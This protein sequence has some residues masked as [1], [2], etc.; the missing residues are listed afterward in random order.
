MTNQSEIVIAGGQESMTNAHHTIN[1]RNGLKMGDGKLKDSMIID[2]LW[3]AM[4][5][6]HM[7]TTAENISEKYNISKQDQDEFATLSQN[8]AEEA[9]KN[10]FESEILNVPVDRKKK[11]L[12]LKT[13][14]FQDMALHW[15]KSVHLN[16]S[17]KKMEL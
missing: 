6:Y 13:T 1:V 10:K 4:N 16:Q 9:Q 5:D 14:N 17:L 2:G 15:K 11:P 3:C 12:T 8:K 7:G